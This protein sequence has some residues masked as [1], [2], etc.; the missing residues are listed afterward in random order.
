MY[1]VLGLLGSG[2]I[3][4]TYQLYLRVFSP[5]IYLTAVYSPC[6]VGRQDRSGWPFAIFLKLICLFLAVLALHCHV[7]FSLVEA[8]IL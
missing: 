4:S 5:G 6:L 2:P 3:Y 1:R 8:S 7:D